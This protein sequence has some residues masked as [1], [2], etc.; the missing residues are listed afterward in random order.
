MTKDQIVSL[1][2]ETLRAITRSTNP[3]GVYCLESSSAEWVTYWLQLIWAR[4]ELARRISQR[5]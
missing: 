4:D 3:A 1:P 2:S 5:A